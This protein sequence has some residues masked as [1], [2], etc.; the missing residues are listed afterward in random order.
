MNVLVVCGAGASSTFV[1]LRLNRAAKAA[2]VDLS[3]RAGTL[4]AVP[5]QLGAVDLLLVGPHLIDLFDD[6]HREARA[7]HVPSL[8]LPDD[9]FT[10]ASGERAL[11]LVRMGA[12]GETPSDPPPPLGTTGPAQS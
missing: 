11:E 6:I 3:A 2:H 7:W 10:D 1:A 4:D 8:L 12:S 5:S 9:V